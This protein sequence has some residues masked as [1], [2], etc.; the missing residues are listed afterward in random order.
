MKVFSVHLEAVELAVTFFLI[1]SVF[2]FC[3]SVNDGSDQLCVHTAP[4]SSPL[5]PRH[6]STA[7]NIS[8]LLSFCP[9]PNFFSFY[10]KQCSTLWWAV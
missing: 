10:C 5:S 1:G 8:L 9:A 6:A 4:L 3:W 2:S 7:F